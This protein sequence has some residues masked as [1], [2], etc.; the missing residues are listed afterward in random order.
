MFCFF[1][2]NLSKSRHSVPPESYFEWRYSVLTPFFLKSPHVYWNEHFHLHGPTC[3]WATENTIVFLLTSIW[4][5]SA[6]QAKPT[7]VLLEQ[8]AMY[9]LALSSS[10]YCKA[11]P[12]E[13]TLSWNRTEWVLLVDLRQLCIAWQSSNFAWSPDLETRERRTMLSSFFPPNILCVWVFLPEC[14]SVHHVCV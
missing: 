7:P 6:V 3:H 13:E 1:I 8:R 14:R 4:K 12:K 10:E 11:L 2:F 9:H 5:Q